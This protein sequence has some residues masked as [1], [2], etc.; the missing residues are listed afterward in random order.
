ME[1]PIHKSKMKINNMKILKLSTIA[2]LLLFMSCNADKGC[3]LEYVKNNYYS[4]D[5]TGL[6]KSV[7]E[8]SFKAVKKVGGIVKGEREREYSFENDS[9]KYFNR[10]V[11]VINTYESEPDGVLRL[12]S[13]VEYGIN[14]NEI[15]VF[16]Y[17]P[18]GN[19]RDTSIYKYDGNVIEKTSYDADWR[20][21]D[22]SDL[23]TYE[24]DENVIVIKLLNSDRSLRYKEV[25][26]YNDK[27][28]RTVR[29]SFTFDGSLDGEFTYK[30][31]EN[32]NVIEEVNNS[33]QRKDVHEYNDKGDIILEKTYNSEYH[34]HEYKYE[35]EYDKIGNWVQQ[36]KFK[37]GQATY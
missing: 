11:N 28:N 14:G 34:T 8:I 9:R 12:R 2:G 33:T 27:G 21:G 15:E 22:I 25:Y 16:N 23:R 37:D 20:S 13:T 35:Y 30:H 19:L 31:D 5:L 26:E 1:H 17:M 6:V 10:D 4:H 32:G 3:T 7:E 18:D 29:R 24:C 36:I